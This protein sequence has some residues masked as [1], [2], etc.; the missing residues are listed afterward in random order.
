MS[1]L[2]GPEAK[3]T[4]EELHEEAGPRP[5]RS[6]RKAEAEGGEL[7]SVPAVVEGQRQILLLWCRSIVGFPPRRERSTG[8][9][10]IVP[11]AFIAWEDICECTNYVPFTELFP[12]L[13]GQLAF[14]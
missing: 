11:L 10:V 2:V 14:F 13:H 1:Y 3:N 12:S 5:F 4:D 8:L 6:V 9:L 7:S